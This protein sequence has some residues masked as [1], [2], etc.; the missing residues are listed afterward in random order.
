VFYIPEDGNR[1]SHSRHN[2][3]TFCIKFVATVHLVRVI[4]VYEDPA[5]RWARLPVCDEGWKASRES[6]TDLQ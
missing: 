5:N 6:Q 4:S 2:L 1:H 3:E